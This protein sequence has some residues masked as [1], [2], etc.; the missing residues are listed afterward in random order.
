MFKKKLILNLQKRR[1]LDQ[2]EAKILHDLTGNFD[3]LFLQEK[4]PNT[5]GFKNAISVVIKNLLVWNPWLN[6]RNNPAGR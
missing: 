6:K 4:L 5:E 2:A 1:K 3:T